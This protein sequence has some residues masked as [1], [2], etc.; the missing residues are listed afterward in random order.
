MADMPLALVLPTTQLHA[1]WLEAHAEWGPGQHEDGF[2]L[3]PTDEVE[4]PDG[5]VAWIKRLHL[6][7]DTGTCQWIVENGRVQGGIAM[8]YQYNDRA[9]H[10]GY[11]IRPSA[12]G[13]GIATW[14]CGDRRQGV[15]PRPPVRLGSRHRHRAD[16]VR[17]I[18]ASYRDLTPPPPLNGYSYD[19]MCRR[20]DATDPP[21]P[22]LRCVPAKPDGPL[23]R[24]HR[25]L[26]LRPGRPD[27]D[28]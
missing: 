22:I 2:G 21:L 25:V 9:G 7:S 6:E 19:G 10:I 18:E 4:T 12:R 8:R 11:G 17:P 28:H 14:G 23:R 20:I 13:R 5:F 1:A 15:R 16:P 24:P 27:G 26:G 3:Q